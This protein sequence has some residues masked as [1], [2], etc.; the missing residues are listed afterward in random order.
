PLTKRWEAW[1]SLRVGDAPAARTVP[2]SR[3]RPWPGARRSIWGGIGGRWRGEVCSSAW[4]GRPVRTTRRILAQQLD[5][6]LQ[7][8]DA[9]IALRERRGD[10]YGLEPLGNVL[11][12]ILIPC[13]NGEQNDLFGARLVPLRHQLCDQLSVA[14]DDARFAPNLDALP[15]CIVDEKQ[16]GLRIV[17]QIALV[18]YCRL[19]AKSTKP[20]VLS[21][22]TRKKPAGPPR[23]WM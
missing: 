14:F 7:C 22:R 12:T 4:L 2:R 19:P 17:R 11:R 18:M 1:P 23:C 9:S 16:L 5:F 13:G 8:F 3:R 20:M 10:V 15:L 6:G 21:S